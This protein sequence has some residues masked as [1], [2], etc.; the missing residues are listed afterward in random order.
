MGKDQPD[1]HVTTSESAPPEWLA[2]Y[3]KGAMSDAKNLYDTQPLYSNPQIPGVSQEGFDQ[4]TEMARSPQ[5]VDPS[6][7]LAQQTLGGDFLNA[8]ALRAASR[9]ELDDVIGGTRSQFEGG[10]RSNSGLADYALGRGVTA[11]MGPAYARERGMQQQMAGMASDLE[12][13]RYQAPQNLINLGLQQQGIEDKFY[14][15]PWER[16]ARYTGIAL[17]G[18]PAQ[19]AGGTQTNTQP[20]YQPDPFSKIAGLAMSGAGL[21][22]GLGWRPFG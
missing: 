15:E 9:A 14:Q 16:L 5:L 4:A 21:A 2:P 11:A 1:E 20:I 7:Q 19:Y 18:N 10:G 12:S 17:G 22:S 8:D 13:S 3:L 6:M